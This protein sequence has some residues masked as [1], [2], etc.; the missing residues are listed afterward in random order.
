MRRNG[1]DLKFDRAEFS[2]L[3]QFPLGAE[4]SETGSETF[5]IAKSSAEGGHISVEYSLAR[6]LSALDVKIDYYGLPR[7]DPGMNAGLQI[8]FGFG[9]ERLLA[10]QPFGVS[11]VHPSGK[12]IRKYPIGDWMTSPQWFEDIFGAVHSQSLIDVGDE[13]RGMLVLHPGLQQWFADEE[14]LRCLVTMYDPWDENQ[15]RN[16]NDLDGSMRFRIVP[17]GKMSNAERWRLAQENLNPPV[18]FAIGP[19]PAEPPPL[20]P[21]LFSPIEVSPRNVCLT[22]FYREEKFFSGRDVATYAG[23]GLTHPYVLRMVEMDGQASKVEVTVP[24]PVGKVFKANLMGEIEQELRAEAAGREPAHGGSPKVR[25]ALDIGA[26]EIATLYMDLMP[27]RKQA[28]DLDAS[29]EVWATVHRV[30]DS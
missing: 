4:V 11:E 29:R 19:K 3:F 7:P 23:T 6:D 28:R 5:L 21:A 9:Y 8:N 16:R 15:F 2:S 1:A 30:E 17:R 26:H 22:S 25:F 20:I 24:G 10:D 18:A 13:G 27:G 12:V 14:G